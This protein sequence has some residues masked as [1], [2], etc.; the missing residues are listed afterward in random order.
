MKAKAFSLIELLIIAAIFSASWR[1]MVR[2]RLRPL[3]TLLDQRS[4]L[5]VI[6]NGDN[7]AIQDA[8]PVECPARNSLGAV[9]FTDGYTP[10]S[11]K[12][13]PA[14]NQVDAA[15]V[16]LV[17]RRGHLREMRQA[18]AELSGIKLPSDHEFH[19]NCLSVVGFVVMLLKR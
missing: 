13:M 17:L 4:G 11:R 10:P 5:V 9:G 3:R 15:A 19:S 18:V 2:R 6:Q 1:R 8:V 14:A 7:L 12:V 16:R